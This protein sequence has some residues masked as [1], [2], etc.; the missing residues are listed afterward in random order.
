MDVSG[1]ISVDIFLRIFELVPYAK[2][3]FP[4]RDEAEDALLKHPYFKG[5]AKRFFNA[6]RMTVENLDAWEVGGLMYVSKLYI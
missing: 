4:F 5:H 3:F 2:Q 1:E 6:L